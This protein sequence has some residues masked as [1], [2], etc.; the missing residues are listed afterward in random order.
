MILL[1]PFFCSI[2]P[3]P[4]IPTH[5][6]DTYLRLL[7]NK[8]FYLSC[9]DI[10]KIC[11]CIWWLSPFVYPVFSNPIRYSIRLISVELNFESIDMILSHH[12]IDTEVYT[13]EMEGDVVFPLNDAVVLML[14]KACLLHF[15]RPKY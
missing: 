13:N 6:L 9:D 1:F 5:H 14:L 7:P 15:H 3:L 12:C 11:C 2:T 10:I 8:S 4:K